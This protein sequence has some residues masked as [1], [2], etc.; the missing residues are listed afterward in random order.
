MKD[1]NT[2]IREEEAVS[3]VRFQ[4][5]A[6]GGGW[7]QGPPPARHPDPSTAAKP[8]LCGTASGM[9][10]RKSISGFSQL[11]LSPMQIIANFIFP[12]QP[13]TAP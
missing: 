13:A 1:T 2:C 7:Q 5:A 9:H 8:T 12:P 4:L 11:L 10:P 6:V 3:V